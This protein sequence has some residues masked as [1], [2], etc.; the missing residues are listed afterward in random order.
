[1]NRSLYRALL[2]FT[3]VGLFS[4]CSLLLRFDPETQACTETGE[5]LAGY[6]CRDGKC[7][8]ADGSD[9]CGGCAS[10]FRCL[11]STGEC[12]PNT[13]ANK[14]CWAGSRCVDNGGTPTCR[15]VEPPALGQLCADDLQCAVDGGPNRVCLRG[16]IQLVQNG[17]MLRQGICVERCG[18]GNSCVTG[19]T[20][21]TGFALGLSAASIQL[22]VPP[23]LI[24]ACTSDLEC[25]DDDLVCTVF[26]HPLV[27]ATTLC[28]QRLPGGAVPGAACE[29][30]SM[31][32]GS[33]CANGL[34]T[35]RVAAA[36]QPQ[37]CGE[38]CD[39]GT[40][41]SGVCEQVEFGVQGLIRHIPMCVPQRT[42]CAP[43]AAD[44]GGSAACGADAPRCSFGLGPAPRCLAACSPD[45]GAF[46]TCPS[47]QSCTLLDAGFRC[48]PTAGCP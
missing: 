12:K 44:A 23:G 37:T 2:A 45:A 48:V 21:C 35:P 33:L 17:G 4:A 18:T 15:L 30:V 6:A 39:T 1:M 5:C 20:V 27:G 10:G 25:S 42:Q 19:G 32:A 34:C 16:A 14:K 47:R 38:P 29:L 8:K 22:C 24:N 43:C 13:C 11:P 3:A 46:P 7:A 26:D 28:D 9:P 36:N 31:D 40:C 41:T